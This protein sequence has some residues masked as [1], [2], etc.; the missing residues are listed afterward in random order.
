MSVKAIDRG[1]LP[2]RENRTGKLSRLVMTIDTAWRAMQAR[3]RRRQ[4]LHR[5]ARLSN[6]TLKDI[7]LDRS[8][9]GSIAHWEEADRSRVRNLRID[10]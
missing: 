4:S 6:R 10:A 8:E 5:L 1:L 3:R 9:I 2:W 7:G